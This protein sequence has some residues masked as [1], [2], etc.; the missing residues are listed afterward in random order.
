MKNL[1]T[2]FSLLL[3]LFFLISCSKGNDDNITDDDNNTTGTF[4]CYCEF[5]DGTGQ[6]VEYEDV[7]ESEAS[8]ECEALGIT[9]GI[10][11][12]GT[13]CNIQ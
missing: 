13:E 12:P 6:T 2:N 7:T 3:S 11:N 4:E 1:L 9:Y 5:P 8:N 10:T